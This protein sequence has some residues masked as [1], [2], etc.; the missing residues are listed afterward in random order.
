L[1]LAFGSAKPV[2]AISKVGDPASNHCRVPLKLRALLSSLFG[3]FPPFFA[4]RL[5]G[6]SDNVRRK[7]MLAERG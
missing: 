7:K 5:D 4:V 6:G 1:P 3:Q 2:S